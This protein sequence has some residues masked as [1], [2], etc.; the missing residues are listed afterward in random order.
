[1]SVV[2]RELE[3]LGAPNIP[4]VGTDT[5]IGSDMI[6]AVG[7]ATLHHIMTNCEAGL[8]SSPA[9]GIFTAE[10]KK[11]SGQAPEA[12]AEFGY[13][14]VIIAALAMDESHSTSGPVFNTA[15]QKVTAQGGT[16]VYSYPQGLAALKAG[17]KIS[18]IGASGP[19]YYNANHNV[20][21]P[22]V[23]VRPTASGS[24]ETLHTF[25]ALQLKSAS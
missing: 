21:G 15:I 24:Y 11:T 4:V 18:Y 10:V 9:T 13:D 5:M 25:S 12:N 17:K 6:K 16:P 20:Y 1:M 2:V 3:S 7:A 8:F 19:F 22:F 14:G 23:C